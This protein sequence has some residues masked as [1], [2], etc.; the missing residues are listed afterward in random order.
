MFSCGSILLAAK[1]RPV[2]DGF[3]IRHIWEWIE[4]NAWFTYPGLALLVIGLIAAALVSSARQE[5]VSAERRGHLKML[6]MGVMRRRVSGVTAE[7]VA[8]DLKID[9]I[10]A[11]K[12]LA[13]LAQEGVIAASAAAPNETAGARYR[14][15]G[16]H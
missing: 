6:I 1:A 15:R 4:N 10:L 8:A 11:G 13:E 3:R 7:T 12:L 2:D 5:E 16:A 14:L 9:L